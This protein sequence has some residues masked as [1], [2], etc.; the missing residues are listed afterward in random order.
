MSRYIMSPRARED[1]KV[2]SR[3]IAKERNSPAG[4][5]I[6]RQR[7]MDHFRKLASQPGVGEARPDLGVSVRQWP[8][9]NYV[10]YYEQIAGG[11]RIIRV[12]HGA[13]DVPNAFRE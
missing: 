9:G 11:V 4:A 10:V 1:I 3:Y 5:S 12:I 8:V 7:L 13:R 6:L 2:I